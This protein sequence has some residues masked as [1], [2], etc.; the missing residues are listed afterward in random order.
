MERGQTRPAPGVLRSRPGRRSLGLVERGGGVR[1]NDGLFHPH[2][3]PLPSRE[4]GWL[5]GAGATRPSIR[6]VTLTLA[7]SH[8]G[9]GDDSGAGATRPSIRPVTL[10]L[11]L[12]HRGRGDDSDGASAA[13][14]PSP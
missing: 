6:P 4:R 9:R 5:S 13:V 14:S 10:T 8:R 12:S 3:S 11:A 1:G 2:P 7:L